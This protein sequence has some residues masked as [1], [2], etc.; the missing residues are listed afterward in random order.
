MRNQVY[1]VH[2]QLRA[3]VANIRIS[4]C[5]D[6]RVE[7]LMIKGHQPSKLNNKKW[8]IW[9]TTHHHHNLQLQLPQPVSMPKRKK[10][11]GNSSFSSS[12]NKEILRLKD[13]GRL[14]TIRRWNYNW[15]MNRKER[16]RQLLK[17][18]ELHKLLKRPKWKQNREDKHNC[19]VTLKAPNKF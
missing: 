18:K 4:R 1:Q 12:S 10:G 19:E 5:K 11:K 3:I 13:N 6:Q 9:T 7:K 17:L 15:P 14:N 8:Q 2:H 16:R